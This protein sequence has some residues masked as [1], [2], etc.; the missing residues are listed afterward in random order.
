MD[1]ELNPDTD[2]LAASFDIVA[3]QDEADKA[4]G[5]L[6]SDVDE[7][8]ARLDRVGR[9]AARPALAVAPPHRSRASSISTC[10]GVRNAS[11]SR[12]LAPFRGM[13][14]IPCR[15]RSMR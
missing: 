14:A 12:S 5:V 4:I 1:S 7:V 6:R 3:R 2:A 9:A 8:K 10:A 15:T 13:A 11:S